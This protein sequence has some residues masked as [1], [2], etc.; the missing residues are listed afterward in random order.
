MLAALLR[1]PP[2][3]DIVEVDAPLPGPGEA[4]LEIV[5]AGVCGTDLA[6]ASG[7]YPVAMPLAPGH[8]FVGRVVDVG[9]GV[10]REW[11]GRRATA[12]INR[13]CAARGRSDLCAACRRG[14]SGHCLTRTVTGIAGAHGAFA[15]RMTTPA[16]ILHAVPDELSDREA[17]FI[18]PLAAAIQTFEMAPLEQGDLVVVLGVGRLGYLI[19]GV[20]RALGARVLAVSRSGEK[21]RRVERIEGV[22]TMPAGDADALADAV[23]ART[24]GLGA[25]HVVEVTGTG[26]GEALALAARL[27]RPRGTIDLKSTPGAFRPGIPITDIVVGEVRLQG[28]RCGPF[29]RAI[30]LARQRLF[31]LA[32]LVQAE[33]ALADANAAI[34]RAAEA[35]K[36]VI[37]CTKSRG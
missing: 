10:S 21:R 11:I 12:E 20:A 18:E 32:D 19:A 1:N 26:D 13:H 36:V 24:D 31:P 3:L 7:D 22:E 25:S 23:R 4:L 16:A 33:F 15:E 17:I 37:R 9:P 6:L 34:A 28:S 14:M 35:A 29:D 30:A 8:E 27:V 2:G 5:L